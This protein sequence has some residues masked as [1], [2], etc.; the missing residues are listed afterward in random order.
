MI[1]P[2]LNKSENIQADFEM[3]AF[4][5]LH[6]AENITSDFLKREIVITIKKPISHLLTEGKWTAEGRYVLKQ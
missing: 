2:D 6:E 4:S 1:G 5:C 3:E